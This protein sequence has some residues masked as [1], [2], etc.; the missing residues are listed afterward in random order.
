MMNA[1]Q[2]SQ[3][4]WVG[5][6]WGKEKHTIVVSTAQRKIVARLVTDT[7]LEGLDALVAFLREFDSIGGIAIETTRN[8]VVVRLLEEGYT[9]YSINPI[10]SKNWRKCTSVAGAKSDERDAIV[11]ATELARRHEDL[12]KMTL[13]DNRVQEFLGL[14][15]ALRCLIDQRTSHLQR[16]RELLQRYYPAALEFWEGLDSPTAWKFIK[17]FP[18]PECL[19]KTRK[20]T[21][22]AFLR[23]NKIGLKPLW[24]ERIEASKK[25]TEW[26]VSFT[27]AGDEIMTLA[28]VGQLFA[29]RAQIQCLEK[30][31]AIQG[32]SFQETALIKS[33]PGAGDALAPAITAIILNIAKDDK[34]TLSSLRCLA[35]IAPVQDESGKRVGSFMRRRCN[36]RW[37][38]IFHLFSWCSINHSRWAKAFYDIC[39]ERGDSFGNTLRKL[40]DKWIRIIAC[41]LRE[42]K[43]YDEQKYIESLRKSSS[44]VY[45]RLCG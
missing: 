11:L 43:P 25:A 33:L 34:E 39:R 17:R 6:D 10:L 4:Y 31:I 24:L 32:D 30:K 5:I 21:L 29:L 40:A 22:I 1:K 14:C 42:N 7:T 15:E 45:E 12:P 16:L 13:K 28:C 37:R 35:G 19:A 20:N 9:I 36:K 27:A 38:N 8:P 18:T 3:T 23:A 26:P 2:K 41:M 44:P